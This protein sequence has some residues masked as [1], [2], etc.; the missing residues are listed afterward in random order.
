MTHTSNTNARVDAKIVPMAKLT[1]R[2]TSDLARR[3]R[4][5]RWH[6]AEHD[7]HLRGRLVR[8][9]TDSP[10]RNGD[11]EYGHSAPGD[12]DRLVET[13]HP[14]WCHVGMRKP[15]AYV[16]PAGVRVEA[17]HDHYTPPVVAGVPYRADGT[18][19]DLCAGWLARRLRTMQSDT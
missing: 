2:V 13:G 15:V 5:R 9:R 8:L 6:H 3:A 1:R 18:A 14:F 10:E 19:G 16:H 12:L 7:Q 11:D 4:K 17:R